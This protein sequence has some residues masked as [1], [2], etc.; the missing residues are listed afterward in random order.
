VNRPIEVAARR[1]DAHQQA[2]TQCRK[3]SATHGEAP[4]LEEN[5]NCDASHASQGERVQKRRTVL[6]KVNLEKDSI[7]ANFFVDRHASPACAFAVG[8][9]GAPEKP[10]FL[11]E[12]W[13]RECRANPAVDRCREAASG[14]AGGETGHDG[15]S[16]TIVG[17]ATLPLQL[18]QLVAIK[19]L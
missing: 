16:V 18:Q 5:V 12:A 4:C 17:T 15:V 1:S 10:R 13:A 11:R 14:L 7:A 3:H 6:H 2:G 19:S 9:P 8:P